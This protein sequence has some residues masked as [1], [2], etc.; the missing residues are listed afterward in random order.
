[1]PVSSTARDTVTDT[2]YDGENYRNRRRP[3]VGLPTYTLALFAGMDG[4]EQ[5]KIKSALIGRQ[6][7]RRSAEL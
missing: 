2:E 4:R 7:C 1:V 6:V 3:T 5:I